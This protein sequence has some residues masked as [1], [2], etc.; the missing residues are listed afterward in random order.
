MIRWAGPA[1]PSGLFLLTLCLIG[2]IF[3]LMTF[4]SWLL[5]RSFWGGERVFSGERSWILEKLNEWFSKLF[6]EEFGG[7]P[8][9]V[10]NAGCVFPEFGSSGFVMN[11][12]LEDVLACLGD[13]RDISCT[14]AVTGRLTRD[15]ESFEI[16]LNVSM[17]CDCLVELG[18]DWSADRFEP[19]GYFEMWVENEGG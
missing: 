8:S 15:V 5:R 13:G 12:R 10:V 18:S 11:T 7:V 1:C 4:S 19:L 2:M 17:S 6:H 14:W 16:G 3:L 9:W